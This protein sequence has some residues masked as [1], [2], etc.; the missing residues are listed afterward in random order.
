[1]R[2][3][4]LA[5]RTGVDQR[6]LRYYEQQGLLEPDRQSNGYRSYPEEAVATVAWIRRLL[7]AGLSTATIAEFR[8][9]VERN[10]DNDPGDCQLLATRLGAERDRIDAAMEALASTRAALDDV[11]A[12]ANGGG[13]PTA[14]TA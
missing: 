12:S 7:R 8:A 5:Q 6:L 2:I 11:I 1:M 10:P 14:E 9:C 4:Q 13:R 3:G